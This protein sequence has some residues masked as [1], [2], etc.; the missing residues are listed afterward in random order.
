MAQLFLASDSLMTR[1]S[2]L[3][4]GLDFA[5]RCQVNDQTEM[6]YQ[7][8]QTYPILYIVLFTG[9]QRQFCSTQLNQLA[10]N[11]A[12]AA[13]WGLELSVLYLVGLHC[14]NIVR[15]V[16]WQEPARNDSREHNLFR[17]EDV[18]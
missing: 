13:K 15:A 6:E 8:E 1:T 10:R 3:H 4:D 9:T 14:L 12:R 11:C 5:P 7:R 17:G 18:G 16:Q 2:V